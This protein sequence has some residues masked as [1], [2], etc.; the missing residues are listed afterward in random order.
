MPKLL[1]CS[2]LAFLVLIFSS[3]F[4]FA[5]GITITTYYPSPYGV[6][7]TLRL[8]PNNDAAVGDACTKAG[9][10]FYRQSSN[11]ILFCDGS[12]WK[13]IGDSFWA[14]GTGAN[15]NDIYNTNTGNVGIGTATPLTKLDVRSGTTTSAGQI[16]AAN[17]NQDTFLQLWSGSNAGANDPSVLWSQGHDLRF[18][19]GDEDG[20]PYTE[21]MRIVDGG[22]VGIGTLSPRAYA[23]L[24]VNTSNNK[25]LY[26]MDSANG[27]LLIGYGGSNIQARETNDGNNQNLILQ[28]WGGNVGIAATDPKGKLDIGGYIHLDY[29]TPWAGVAI[30]AKPDAA[31]FA[32]WAR[33]YSF[34]TPGYV[35]LGGYYAF[36]NPGTLDFLFMGS[37]YANYN[38]PWVMVTKVGRLGLGTTPTAPPNYTLDIRTGSAG[39]I[40]AHWVD[41]SSSDMRCK[42]NILP[43]TNA[44]EKICQLKP[45]SFEWKNTEERGGDRA[46]GIKQGFIAQDVEKIFP[47]WVTEINATGKDKQLTDNGKI[48]TLD[49]PF[50]FDSYVVGAIKEL[51]SR[52]Q[53]LE[54]KNKELEQRIKKLESKLK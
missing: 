28:G 44:L 3:S 54:S 31:P 48:K 2:L 12:I 46:K 16:M 7:K 15:I 9:E 27:G 21:Y 25:S 6:Y 41:T 53:A 1:K 45:V 19:S 4:V 20:N 23:A 22:N 36:G 50:A 10:M 39:K 49:L 11:Q 24:D 26:T 34:M 8:F 30:E 32:N 42:K 38:T 5:E 37:S 43:L 33:G 47:D 17:S 29:R 40:G 14:A 52:N 35:P 18:G 13:A 51:N